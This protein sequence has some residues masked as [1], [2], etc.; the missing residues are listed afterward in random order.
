MKRNYLLLFF[1]F[2]SV[3]SYA[4]L[5]IQS[6]ATFF[7]QAG[8]TVTVQGDVVSNADIQGTG[9]L[10][11]KGT[12]AQNVNM[13]GFT[14]N[15]NVE[16][17]N[18]NHITLTGLARTSGLLTFTNGKIIIGNNNFIM[19]ST[20][21]FAGA[22][23]GKFVETNGTG[24]F[25]REIAAN[26]NVVL[27]LG[28]GTRYT[29]LEYQIA[30]AVLAAA[31]VSGR[32]VNG[33]HPNKHPRSS[34]YLNQFWSLTTSG[35]TGGTVT[36]VGSYTEGTDLTGIEADIRTVTWNGANW[37]LGTSQNNAANTV[38]AGLTG[39]SGDLY[40][41]NRFLLASPTVYLQSAFNVST[42]TLMN[43]LLRNSGA[44]S[45]GVYPASNLI[46]LTDPYRS[47]PYSANYTHVNNTVPETILQ[48]VLN[49]QVV[50]ANNIVDW[51]YVE[52]RTIS[53]PTVAPVTQTRSVLLRRDGT[54]V[55]V[56]GVSP[57]YF[58]NVDPGNYVLS[59]RH[60][61]HLGIS[62]S[63]A[64]PTPLN[65]SPSGFNFGTAGGASLFGV[66]NTNYRVL[67]GLNVMWA[68]NSNHN[69]HVRY[70]GID[71]DK[72]VLQAD[73]ILVGAPANYYR[74]DINFNRTVRYTGIN[75]DKDFLLA[76]IIN[77]API[78]QKLQVLPN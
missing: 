35:I 30:G 63:P 44:Y 69:T 48:S 32:S 40:A 27:P 37:A 52:L 26:G 24:Q 20:G 49:D 47:A 28:T 59:I 36:T 34:D 74:S 18:T 65:I 8:A 2:L 11:L 64:A 29:P 56:D 70:T 10:L 3:G 62:I 22:A 71:N 54:L 16:I 60:R 42:P 12:S 53:S 78:G 58:K 68:G 50:A 14:V 13:N 57:V 5:T 17:D 75:N 67:S 73:F 31:Y 51:V 6:G 23:T 77:I 45:P 61:N 46:P 76:S 33:G 66:A 4:Q 39:T 21:T 41:M 15:A 1:A 7:I 25:R 55:D 43:D 38:T 9:L 72:D 19:A